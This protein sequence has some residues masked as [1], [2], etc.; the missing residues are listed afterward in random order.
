MTEPM[1]INFVEENMDSNSCRYEKKD[2]FEIRV[3][4][5]TVHHNSD[6]KYLDFDEKRKNSAS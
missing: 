3:N 4:D 2:E 5:E 6:R 1:S